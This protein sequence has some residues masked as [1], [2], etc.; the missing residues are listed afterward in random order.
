M[1][2]LYADYT[3][4][5]VVFGAMIMGLVSGVMGTFV[6]LQEQSL[7]A[8]AI[9]HAALPGIALMFLCTQSK[10]TVILL[11]GGGMAAL[12]GAYLIQLLRKCTTLKQDTILGVILSVFFGFGTVLLSVIQKMQLAD[13]AIVSKFLFGNAATLLWQDILLMAIVAT[14]V[15]LSS[16]IWHK[17]LKMFLFDPQFARAS[18]YNILYI[19][20]G[21]TLLIIVTILIG[22]QTVGVILMSSFFIAPAATARQ[23]THNFTK[24]IIISG[25]LGMSTGAIGATMSCYMYHIPTGPAIVILLTG[26][27]LSSCFI[28]RMIR[29]KKSPKEISQLW[30]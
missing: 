12:L 13:Q 29:M 2:I 6:F 23:Y 16:Y 14:I 19:H 4:F 28:I 22:L 25:L 20:Y 21:L 8:D 30:K 17:E 7:L 18:G 24:M 5:I 11:Y 3:F 1:N 15:L 27:F 9:S 26:V 10:N